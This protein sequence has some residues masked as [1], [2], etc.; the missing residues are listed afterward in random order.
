M[1]RF[2]KNVISSSVIG[3]INVCVCVKA[4]KKNRF[5]WSTVYFS[6][7]LSNFDPGT[8]SSSVRTVKD[9]M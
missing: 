6:G 7:S 9:V 2:V 4:I 3:I 8:P 5:T 1:F